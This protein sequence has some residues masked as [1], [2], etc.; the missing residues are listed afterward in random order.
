M[1]ETL[2]NV[3]SLLQHDHRKGDPRYPTHE[4]DDTKYR[5]QYKH[6][7]RRVIML[8]EVIHSRSDTEYDLK[9]T[10]YPYEL[11]CKCSCQGK[12]APGEDE[13]NKEHE[14][15]EDNGV[16]VEGEFVASV[17]DTSTG[18]RFIG[19]VALER[20]ARNGYKPEKGENE[21]GKLQ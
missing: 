1:P 4:T 12:V 20:K 11:F 7:R 3:H 9:D 6:H 17:V 8:Y 14:Y 16:R 13:G 21:L 15:E 18:E 10:G 5:K 2:R 19:T